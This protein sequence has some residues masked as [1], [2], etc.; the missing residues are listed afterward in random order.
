MQTRR[1]LLIAT[2][3][4]FLASVSPALAA[5]GKDGRGPVVVL[6]GLIVLTPLLQFCLAVL[7]PRFTLRVSRA[8]RGGF[9]PCVGWGA[10]V[11][12]L[13]AVVAA[14]FAQGGAAGKGLATGVAAAA[15][16][17]AVAGGIGLAKV[18]GDWA[19]HRWQVEPQGPFSVL[20]G[21]IVW[22]WGAVLPV[23]GWATGLLTLLMGLGAAVQVILQPRCFDPPEETAPPPTS[24]P[25]PP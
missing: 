23:V 16:L 24:P 20:C 21:A 3:L 13:V 25:T 4:G 14:I 19:L 17:T 9:W 15:V 6:L 2:A 12:V 8:V 11:A 18:M 22:A 10:L 1:P 7:L 5:G